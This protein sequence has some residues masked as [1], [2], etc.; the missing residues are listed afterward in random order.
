MNSVQRLHNL[1]FHKKKSNL[2]LSQSPHAA[3]EHV[4]SNPKSAQG[5]R[6]ESTWHLLPAHC[7]AV[8]KMAVP[9]I[10]VD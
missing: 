9:V 6:H 1:H 8:R 2:V 5:R 10:L 4:L 7:N 3:R